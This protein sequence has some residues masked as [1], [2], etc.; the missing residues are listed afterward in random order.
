MDLNEVL[1]IIRRYAEAFAEGRIEAK[2]VKTMSDEELAAFDAALTEQ[3]AAKQ[4]EADILAGGQKVE[5]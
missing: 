5:N 4:R 2:A 1:A 3:L